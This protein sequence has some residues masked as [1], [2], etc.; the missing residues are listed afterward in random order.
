MKTENNSALDALPAD[1]LVAILNLQLL[2][3]EGARIIEC[4]GESFSKFSKSPVATYTIGLS[5]VEIDHRDN[6]RNRTC[7]GAHPEH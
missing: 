5:C 1:R 6:I 2:K 3:S 7:P 4:R